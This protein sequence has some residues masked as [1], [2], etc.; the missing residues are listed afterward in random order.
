MDT[1]QF[2]FD[3][4]P[5]CI[6]QVPAERRDAS[7]LMVVDRTT[8]RISH[9]RFH[10][11]PQLLPPGTRLFRNNAAVLPARLRATRP[12]GGAVE[13]LLLHPTPDEA[14]RWWC[15][16]RPGKKLPAGATFG[17]DGQF[18]ATVEKK[19]ERGPALVRFKVDGAR[20][21]TALAQALGE[22]PLPPYIRRERPE[23]AQLD[24]ERYQ[25]VYA[26]PGQPVA[27]A[28]PTAGLHFTPELLERL[29]ADGFRSHDLS[30]HVG[31]D[32][33]QPIQT[34][35]VEDHTIHTETYVIPPET[36]TELQRPEA[37][38]RLAVGTTSLRALE[39]C[40]RKQ[41][42]GHRGEDGQ[43]FVAQAD[44]YIY[45]PAEFANA[46]ALITNFHLP[47]S[48][49][50]CL[51]SAFLTPGRTEGINWLKTLYTEAITRGYRFFSYGDAMLIRG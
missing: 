29:E 33:F 38:P 49:L 51:V 3:L 23:L 6:A 45:P 15:L 21:V 27:A 22:M 13:C 12:T 43:P 44:I 20:S 47:R 17:L 32:T 35:T 14:N 30:L 28:A 8:Q 46:D 11:L 19:P 50:L 2:D 40:A 4:P 9:H 26:A 10:E 31:L 5:Q 16:L 34:D 39:D 7:R 18:R 41:A 25:T 24:R 48:T 42:A 1:A 37:G 36:L